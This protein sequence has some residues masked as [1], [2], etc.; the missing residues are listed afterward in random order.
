MN[1]NIPAKR[2]PIATDQ[3]E[4][5]LTEPEAAQYIRM[6]RSYLR[7]DRMNGRNVW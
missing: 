2:T 6:S 3:N 1:N 7:Q 4:I 5:V